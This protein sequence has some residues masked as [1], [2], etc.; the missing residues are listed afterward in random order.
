MGGKKMKNAGLV[1]WTVGSSSVVPVVVVPELS[2]IGPCSSV[3]PF[4]RMKLPGFSQGWAPLLC[5][6]RLSFL[7]CEGK[8]FLWVCDRRRQFWA[9]YRRRAGW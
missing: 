6:F 4:R 7:C 5:G 9:L 1:L 3:A 2:L 8:V